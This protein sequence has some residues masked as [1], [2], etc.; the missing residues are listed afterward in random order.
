MPRLFV[1]VWP[2]TSVLDR[3]AAIDRTATDGVRW[4]PLGN[5]HVTIRFLGN[6]EESGARSSLGALTLPRATATLAEHSTLL[7]GNVV[8]LVTGLETLADVVERATTDVVERREH[9]PFRGGITLAR[10]KDRRAR[11][12][13]LATTATDESPRPLTAEEA[14]LVESRTDQAGAHYIVVDRW[15]TR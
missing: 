6:V 9:R 10:R 2:S 11:V 7:G 14:T 1:A 8:V 4:V 15:P 12:G 13:R 5:L 3:L